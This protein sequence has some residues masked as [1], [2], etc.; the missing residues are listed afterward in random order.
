MAEFSVGL[1][2]LDLFLEGL[3]GASDDV[4]KCRPHQHLRV[5]CG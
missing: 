4:Q 2:E 1:T 3:A 5:L